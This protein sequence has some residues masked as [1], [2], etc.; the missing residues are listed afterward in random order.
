MSD[1]TSELQLLSHYRLKESNVIG[2]SLDV[3]ITELHITM[4]LITCITLT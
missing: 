3:A 2:Q 1:V 4:A